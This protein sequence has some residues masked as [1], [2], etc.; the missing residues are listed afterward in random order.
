MTKNLTPHPVFYM[1][2]PALAHF[3]SH[4]MIF[5]GD[6][7]A[8]T[9]RI[10]P[11]PPTP[12]NCLYFYPGDP[13]HVQSQATGSTAPNSIIVGPQVTRVNIQMGQHHIIVS[14]VFIPGGLFKWLGI[15]L[16]ELYD[17][18]FDASLLI[19]PAIKEVNEKLKSVTSHLAMKYIVE[20]F[21]LKTASAKKGDRP[22]DRAMAMMVKSNGSLSME[23]A[24]SLSC[25]S[26][27]QF[28]R[29]SKEVIGYSPKMF[30]RIIRF[31]GAYRLKEQY[32]HMNWSDIIYSSG[33]FDQMHLIRDFK[34][35][36]GVNPS[37]IIQ[38]LEFSPLA[39][40]QNVKL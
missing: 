20:A 35:F 9:N 39:K 10:S 3:V 31:S 16:N 27:R 40:L 22:F 7:G 26:L 4:I 37:T 34:Q 8:G 5:E 24:A 30:A 2:H 15:P 21:L 14:V 23:K 17:T 6:F 33:Y 19:G 18:A 11:F 36:T 12:Q 29:V 38:E 13:T 28:E 1:P 25:L 32:P